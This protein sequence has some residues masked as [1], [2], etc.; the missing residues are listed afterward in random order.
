[1]NLLS[2]ETFAEIDRHF[3]T[4]IAQ[5]GGDQERV[6]LAA[7]VLSRAV[8]EGHIC[9]P[10]DQRP[11]DLLDNEGSG[12]F[13]WPSAR[14]WQATL[15][16]SDAVG[17]PDETK[18]L[19]LDS[20]GR[21]YLRRYWDYQSRLAQALREKVDQNRAKASSQTDTQDQAIEFAV[22]NRLTIISGGPGTGKTTTVLQILRR[23]LEQP[24]IERLRIALATPTG[25]AAARLEDT[26]R[27]GLTRLECPESI[28]DRIPRQ[29]STIHRLLGSRGNS[30]Y[31][32][33]DNRNPLPI[34]LL[35]IDEASMVALPL[36]CKVF[37]ALPTHSRIILLGD[38][39]QLASVE[40]GAVLADMVESGATP[41]SPLSNAVVTLTTNYRFGSES[42]V[43]HLCNAI[44]KGQIPEATGVLRKGT[45]PDLVSREIHDVSELS[46]SLAKTVLTGFTGLTEV[47]EPAH[48]LATLERFRVLTALRR[49]RFGVEGL[50]REIE[51]ILSEAELIP[52]SANAYYRGKPILITQNDHQLQLYNG[53]VGVLLPDPAVT[54]LPEQLWAWFV[55]R[56]NEPRRF[57][58]ARLPEHE[59]AY[60]MTVHKSQGSEFER[61]LFILPDTDSPVLTRELIYTGLTRARTQVEFWWNEDIF[62]AAVARRA[63]RF[64]G[65][66]DL[67]G[68]S[69]DKTPTGKAEQLS[70]F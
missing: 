42:G 59:T 66:R 57:A 56:D 41:G 63:E 46:T 68:A 25:K 12:S 45:H 48:A 64:S 40:P 67:L 65:L 13:E 33:H 11:A 39:E 53:D 19:V 7:A 28:K 44:R 3:A 47:T 15:A 29:A 50:N 69:E 34:D 9:W 52:D 23:L 18:P 24:G 17:S 8:R 70:L 21:L 54:K 51:R 43:H 30:V 55:G 2:N 16:A 35:V 14:Q 20:K 5:F 26:I 4:F 62:S 1:M 38:H 58:P 61:V 37:D 60:A 31:F 10:I 22:A 36:L 27:N 32:R 49:G 6:P